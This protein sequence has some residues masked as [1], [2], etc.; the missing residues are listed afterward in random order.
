MNPENDLISKPRLAASL[1]I[2]SRT[3]SRWMCDGA[4]AFPKSATVN[5]R[6]FFRV[7]DIE[8]WKVEKLREA[9]ST[10]APFRATTADAA[11]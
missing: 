3:L 6:H 10:R 7:A 11:A 8:A 1:G 4:I 2:S 9:V 5:G